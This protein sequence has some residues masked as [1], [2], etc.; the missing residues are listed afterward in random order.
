MKPVDVRTLDIMRISALALGVVLA[1][2]AVIQ[3]YQAGVRPDAAEIR[4]L[5]LIAALEIAFVPLA[6]SFLLPQRDEDPLAPTG[7]KRGTSVPNPWA[8]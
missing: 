3:Y 5:L 2:F 7:L 6:I 8:Y 1:I 4:D